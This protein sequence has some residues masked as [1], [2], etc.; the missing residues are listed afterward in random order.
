LERLPFLLPASTFAADTR[1]AMLYSNS[2]A[3]STAALFPS[4]RQFF[5]ADRV[6]TKAD[7]VASIK[8]RAPLCWSRPI[9]SSSSKATP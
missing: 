8:A 7:L 2:T 4:R 3:G 1:A 6:Q 9:H 5:S